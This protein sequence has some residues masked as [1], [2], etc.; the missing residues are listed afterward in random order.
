[1][2]NY[3]YFLDISIC[4][5]RICEGHGASNEKGRRGELLE[6]LLRILEGIVY[7]VGCKIKVANYPLIIDE[8]SVLYHAYV[9]MQLY[10]PHHYIK[11]RLRVN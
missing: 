4:C 11:A 8:V 7:T 10:Q 3:M 1:M 9:L 2:K 6:D 5:R